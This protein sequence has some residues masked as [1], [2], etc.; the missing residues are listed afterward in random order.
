M[1]QIYCHRCKKF[2]ESKSPIF[3]H[4]SNEQDAFRTP[5]NIYNEAFLRKYLTAFSS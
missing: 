5:S 1:F 2:T 4:N 3:L